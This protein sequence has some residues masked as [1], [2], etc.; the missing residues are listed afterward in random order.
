VSSCL[1]ALGDL[2]VRGGPWEVNLKDF[3]EGLVEVFWVMSADDEGEDQDL[4]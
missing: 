3:L 4:D 1:E 2:E